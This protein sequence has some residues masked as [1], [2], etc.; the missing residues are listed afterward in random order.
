MRNP[1]KKSNPINMFDAKRKRQTIR[2]RQRI[3]RQM[4]IIEPD[5][6]VDDE[7]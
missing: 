2:Q 4:E 1:I 5:E 3:Q 6:D 7:I